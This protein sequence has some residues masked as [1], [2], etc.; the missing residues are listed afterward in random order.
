MKK[1]SII[2]ILVLT[3]SA[4]VL[5]QTK[6]GSYA[7][8]GSSSFVLTSN[9]S[10]N[11][12][13]RTTFSIQP[14]FGKFV[15][16]KWLIGGSIGYVFDR[17]NNKSFNF[18]NTTKQNRFGASFEATRFYPLTEKF[19][20]TMAYG[21]GAD[22]T[23]S[24]TE[25]FDGTNT[26]D[27]SSSSIAPSIGASPGLAYFINEKWMVFTRLGS[28]SYRGSFASNSDAAIHTLGYSFQ[29][30]SF[31]LGAKYVFGSGK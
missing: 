30:N 18:E 6:K 10:A 22:Y 2:S 19:Y 31:G 25:S 24:R 5:A 8:G 15:S 27:I 21:I 20:F 16:E 4:Q 13:L 3:C 28:L 11:N 12:Y 17:L 14:E 26:V 23:T 1:F 7:V 29:G 9:P